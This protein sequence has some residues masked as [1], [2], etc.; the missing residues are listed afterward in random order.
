MEDPKTPIEPY[1]SE[2]KL[3][4]SEERELNLVQNPSGLIDE[5][6]DLVGSFAIS[7]LP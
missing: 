7:E 3:Y 4:A 6:A 5:E 2:L 1:R